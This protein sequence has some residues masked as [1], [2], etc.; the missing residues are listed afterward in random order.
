MKLLIMQFSPPAKYL[1]RD[2]TIL[3]H[4]ILSSVMLLT[5]NHGLTTLVVL[6]NDITTA[7]VTSSVWTVTNR[8][9]S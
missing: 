1:E 5:I 7:P 4:T 3:Y 8:V 6:L 9:E 2:I